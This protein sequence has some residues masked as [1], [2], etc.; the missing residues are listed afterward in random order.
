VLETQRDSCFLLNP[1][2]GGDNR[3]DDSVS[4]VHEQTSTAD[5]SCVTHQDNLLGHHNFDGELLQRT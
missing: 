4:E 5:A 2:R 1:R 3:A